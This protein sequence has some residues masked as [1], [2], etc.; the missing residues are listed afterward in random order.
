MAFYCGTGWRGSEAWFNAWLMG[1]PKVSV[2]DG[3]W[4]E[5]SADPANSYE[6]GVP[7]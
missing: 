5:W 6:T 2:Y 1:W 7:A 4:F 3:G